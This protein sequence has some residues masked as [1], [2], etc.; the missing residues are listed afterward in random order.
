MKKKPQTTNQTRLRSQLGAS[1]NTTDK[2]TSSS[3]LHSYHLNVPDDEMNND[4]IYF[5][6]EVG[7]SPLLHLVNL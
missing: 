3:G 7:T 6:D 4:F 2:S 1:L 5:W